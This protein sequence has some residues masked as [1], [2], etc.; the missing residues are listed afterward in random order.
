MPHGDI[1]EKVKEPIIGWEKKVCE[2]MPPCP[3]S[4]IYL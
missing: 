1:H 3:K 2:D 4:S